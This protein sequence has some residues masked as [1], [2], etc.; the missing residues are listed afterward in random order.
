MSA[1][2]PF[3]RLLWHALHSRRLVVFVPDAPTLCVAVV[4]SL[5][6][7]E[8]SAVM[9]AAVDGYTA[10]AEQAE[11]QAAQ[12]ALLEEARMLVKPKKL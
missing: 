12:A 5:E 9:C 3:L 8:W 11:A 4:G 10:S 7:A 2:R 6:P 1:F